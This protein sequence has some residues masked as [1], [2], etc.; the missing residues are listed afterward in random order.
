MGADP[1][2]ALIA[3]PSNGSSSPATAALAPTVDVL[4]D[5]VEKSFVA[6]GGKVVTAL[7]KVST[8]ILRGEF[9]ALIGPSGCGKSTLLRLI[10]GLDEPTEG[11][12]RVRSES[13][14][15]FCAR[16]ELGIVFSRPRAAALA[17]CAPQRRAAARG[18]WPAPSS[19]P[20]RIS[21]A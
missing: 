7:D 4:V 2:R 14:K 11:M 1:G 21:R 13:P 10:A 18:A 5:H 16:G 3:S 19:Q 9:V 15:T 6:N 8:T 12:V 20:R 17:F